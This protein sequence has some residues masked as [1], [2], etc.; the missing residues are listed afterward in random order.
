MPGVERRAMGGAASRQPAGHLLAQVSR[1]SVLLECVTRR[2]CLAGGR[3]RHGA[4]RDTPGGR[5]G[6]S[7]AGRRAIARARWRIRA[8]GTRSCGAASRAARRPG[9]RRGTA[10]R[11]TTGAG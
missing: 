3:T 6:W 2:G 10:D 5:A 8:A 11:R 7:W 1:S 9:T 4:R